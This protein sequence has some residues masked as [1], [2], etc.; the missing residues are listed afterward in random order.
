MNNNKISLKVSQLE[1][2]SLA[3][4]FPKGQWILKQPLQ[5]IAKKVVRK[6]VSPA[7]QTSKVNVKFINLSEELRAKETQKTYPSALTSTPHSAVKENQQKHDKKKK[8]SNA[9]TRNIVG[10]W[11]PGVNLEKDKNP[12]FSL[13]KFVLNS[14]K[15]SRTEPLKRT[16]VPMSSPQPPPPPPPPP[17][18]PVE[19]EMDSYLKAL[20]ESRIPCQN[21]EDPTDC[22]D[23]THLFKPYW[24]YNYDTSTLLPH[25][26]LLSSSTLYNEYSSSVKDIIANSQYQLAGQPSTDSNDFLLQKPILFLSPNI[27]FTIYHHSSPTFEKIHDETALPSFETI[28]ETEPSAPSV[29][30]DPSN[31]SETSSLDESLVESSGLG[32]VG[33]MTNLKVV[34]VST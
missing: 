13:M 31:E 21:L 24:S 19:P 29:A 17:A 26:G 2:S 22:D 32:V 18:V 27:K 33:A 3:R 8:N 20:E 34:P 10:V 1:G 15:S 28:I 5:A 11:G 6:T 9:I 30:D 23:F 16:K 4:G 14:L 25:Q 12:K 7:Q